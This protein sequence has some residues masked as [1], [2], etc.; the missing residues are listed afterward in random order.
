MVMCL[1]KWLNKHNRIYL[2]AEFLVDEL[3][4]ENEASILG[5]KLDPG[6]RVKNLRKKREWGGNGARRTRCYGR[7]TYGVNVVL[8]PMSVAAL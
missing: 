6:E 3:F 8:D 2:T 4:N 1:A 5:L 7:K